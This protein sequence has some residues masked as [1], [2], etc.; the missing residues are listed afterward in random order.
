MKDSSHK[1]GGV[2]STGLYRFAVFQPVYRLA[3]CL[4]QAFLEAA[5]EVLTVLQA[6]DK[7]NM[8]LLELRHSTS[9]G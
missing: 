2:Q 5:E 6:P 3:A 8:W 7:H 4:P 9:L 1:I